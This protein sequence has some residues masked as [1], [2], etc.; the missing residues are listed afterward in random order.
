MKNEMTATKIEELVALMHKP[1]IVEYA[2]AS[3]DHAQTLGHSRTGCYFVSRLVEF[4]K[5][6]VLASSHGYATKEEAQAVADLMYA[7]CVYCDAVTDH[8]ASDDT[9]YQCAA[10]ANG[11]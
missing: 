5:P 9:E 8:L 4:N 11:R 2:Y 6:R 3:S 7:R 10:C 1:F